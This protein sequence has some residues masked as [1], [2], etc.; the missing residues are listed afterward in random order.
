MTAP[1]ITEKTRATKGDK[2]AM[3]APV[4]TTDTPSGTTKMQFILPAEY[5]EMSKIPKPTNTNVSVVQV[6]PAVGAVHRFSGSV[7]TT[8]STAKAKELIEQLKKDGVDVN[9]KEV[10]D[11]YLLWQF[12]PPFTVPFLRRNEIWVELSEKDVKDLMKSF[13]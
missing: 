5:D 3:T 10:M 4:V 2:I 1:V 8:K 13:E 11:K 7:D 9:E 12:H 6:P